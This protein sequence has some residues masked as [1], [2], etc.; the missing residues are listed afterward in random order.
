MI[1]INQPTGLGDILFTVPIARHFIEQGEKVVYPYDPIFGNIEKHFPDIQ[2]IPKQ[3]LNIDYNRRTEIEVGGVRIIPMRWSNG[4]GEVTP[5]TMRSKY[6]LVDLPMDLWRS[7]TWVEDKPKQKE[8]SK[9]L[10]LPKQYI[11]L[12]RTWHHTN[13]FCDLFIHNPKKLPIVKMEVLPGF[14]LID[15]CEVMRN[16]TEF[17]TVGTSNIYLIELMKMKGVVHLYRRPNER[18]F[19]NYD[20][21]LTKN[22][23][24]HG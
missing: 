21:L 10:K 8:L 15:W 16:A 6:S 3:F 24:F 22:Y 11:L 5:G 23:I 17:H 9:L 20:Y 19:K 7:L 2:F 1:I 14:T 12:N 18:D 4:N 13:R